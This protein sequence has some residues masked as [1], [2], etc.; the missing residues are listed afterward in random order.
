[1][2]RKRGVFLDEDDGFDN[3]YEAEFKVHTDSDD[4]TDQT[5]DKQIKKEHTA[6]DEFADQF[7]PLNP[8]KRRQRFTSS[9]DR[10]LLVC[11][12]TAKKRNKPM[13]LVFKQLT[14][15]IGHS[16]SSLQTRLSK[17]ESD[18]ALKQKASKASLPENVSVNDI[19]SK[20]I[21]KRKSRTRLDFTH[22]DDLA[23]KAHVCELDS[24][25]RGSYSA[26]E[27]FAERYPHH[28]ASSVKGRWTKILDKRTNEID[29]V[30]ANLKFS[31]SVKRQYMLWLHKAY[32]TIY[33]S[34]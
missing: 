1:M 9:E 6:G 8:K 11:A 3:V 22:L 34:S 20:G 27:P 14:K 24:R 2:T 32:P 16:E 4:E 29:L 5:D 26:Y 25:H 7:A 18:L 17:L 12:M 28:S 15:V 19:F 30:M 33:N 10:L 21:L 13:K 23:I 31:G